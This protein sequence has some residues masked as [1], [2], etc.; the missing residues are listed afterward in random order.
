[1]VVCDGCVNRGSGESIQ[2]YFRNVV[3]VKIEMQT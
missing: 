2:I 3:F 1:M